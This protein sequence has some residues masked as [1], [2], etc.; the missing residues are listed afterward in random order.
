VNPAGGRFGL[1]ADFLIAPDGTVLACKYGVHAYDQWS[2]DDLLT[3]AKGVAANRSN[4]KAL[5]EN[6]YRHN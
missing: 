2:G 3:L 4:S 5:G 6:R 1:P